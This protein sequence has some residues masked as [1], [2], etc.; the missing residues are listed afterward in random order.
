MEH[1]LQPDGMRRIRGNNY[2]L[3]IGHNLSILLFIY[4][5]M[6]RGKSSFCK[7]ILMWTF[8]DMLFKVLHDEP[9][10]LFITHLFIHVYYT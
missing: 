2:R 1:G 3:L 8:L 5:L 9:Y 4:I 6:L 7:G 10:L